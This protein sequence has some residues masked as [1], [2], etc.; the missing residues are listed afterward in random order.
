LFFEFVVKNQLPIF[1]SF[2]LI[3]TAAALGT[4]E[5]RVT[6]DN[7]VFY[8]PGNK[9]FQDVLAFEAEYISSNNILFVLGLPDQLH[10]KV[11]ADA[12]RWLTAEVWTIDNVVRVDSLATYPEA[13]GTEE[14]L[15]VAPLLDVICP[16]DKD[17]VNAVTHLS[18]RPHLEN[19][20]V[21]SSLTSTG[22][23]ATFNIDVGTITD[24]DSISR[25]T[26]EV[27]LD[28]KARYPGIEIVSTGG[29]PMMA[30]FASASEADL[31]LLLPLAFFVMIGLLYLFLGGLLP[32]AILVGNSLAAGIFAM[33]VAG[34]MGLKINNATSIV[35]LV[36]FTLVVA[37]AMHL[38]LHYL[39]LKR[40]TPGIREPATAA[41]AALESNLGPCI[42]STITSVV[43]LLSLSFVDSPPLQQLGQLSAI[44]LLFGSLSTL[45][46]VPAVL[47]KVTVSH[48]SKA[49]TFLQKS[50]NEY[51]K[52]L[53]NH[54]SFAGVF[55]ILLLGTIVGFFRLEIDDDFVDYFDKST[56]FRQQTD[57]ATELLSGPN[58]IEVLLKNNDADGVFSPDY[59][60]YLEDL[61]SELRK[62][63]I[64]NNVAS[65]G[66]ILNE[67]SSAFDP[68][69][70]LEAT[71]GTYAQWYLAYELSLQR[72]QSNTDFVNRAQNESRISVLLG[73]TTSNDIQNLEAEIYAW[74]HTNESPFELLVTGENI[75]VAHVSELNIMSMSSGLAASIALVALVTGIALKRLKLGLVALIA[76]LV[77]VIFGFG[78]WGLLGNNIGLASTAIIALTIGVVIDDTVHILYRFVDGKDRLGLSAWNA[79]AYSIHRVGTA[80]CT[81]TIAMVG[82]LGVLLFS[83]FKVNTNFGMVTCLIICIALIF[84]LFILPKLLVLTD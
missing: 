30:A 80:I 5:L 19:R 61:V 4:T 41:K 23:L 36:V 12:I 29:V 59:V 66:D 84:D 31:S 17:C 20:L 8:G 46:L 68:D 15:E 58:H 72:G 16:P 45:T 67:I 70:Q 1:L 43:G 65:Y 3:F 2:F 11:H 22:V 74:H 7:R 42:V 34:W 82:G 9:Q 25:A 83:S 39:R 21:N 51:A 10:S 79:A 63:K 76:T 35:P 26:S 57:R 62:K 38:V 69:S 24:I 33:G 13:F 81:T 48:A 78:A 6:P 50:L 55:S 64:V 71:T 40:E 53:E 52:V 44:G 37:S 18:G 77:P 54:R 73:A 56:D 49:S 60:A 28:F 27:L 75:P 47:S 14:S 32:T